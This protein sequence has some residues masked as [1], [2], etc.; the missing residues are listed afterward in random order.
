MTAFASSS[1]RSRRAV[2]RLRDA[3]PELLA[4]LQESRVQLEGRREALGAIRNATWL[5]ITEAI[6]AA[7]AAIAKA[8]GGVPFP[9]GR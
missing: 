2:E 5:R 8:T 6:N 3:A 1:T 7:D 9:R 4:A